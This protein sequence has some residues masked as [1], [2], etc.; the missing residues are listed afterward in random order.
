M[1]FNEGG[2]MSMSYAD[3]QK[4]RQAKMIEEYE[5]ESKKFVADLLAHSSEYREALGFF[6][7]QDQL[8]GFLDVEINVGS[9]LD[10]YTTDK[11]GDGSCFK[12]GYYLYIAPYHN[13]LFGQV[14]RVKV[15]AIV[16]RLCS[17]KNKESRSHDINLMM[18]EEWW[19]FCE[20]VS[21]ED[22]K[23]L[24]IPVPLG[25][26]IFARFH[27]L[28]CSDGSS[29]SCPKEWMEGASFYDEDATHVYHQSFNFYLRMGIVPEYWHKLV[30]GQILKQW[31]H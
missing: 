25:P 16:F 2:G 15:C 27:I 30:I 29:H 3:G 18:D 23:V 9:L 12:D 10:G 28:K 1:I 14:V 7:I 21:H 6:D 17:I 4:E 24:K 5:R 22:P 19:D 11:L 20:F 13:K 8:N 26:H 31:P